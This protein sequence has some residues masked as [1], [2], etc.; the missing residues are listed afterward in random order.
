MSTISITS[1]AFE[2]GQP[3][4]EVYSQDGKNVSPPLEWSGVP[5]QVEELVLIVDDPDAPMDKPYVH[6]VMVGIPPSTDSLQEGVPQDP[7]PPAPRGALQGKNTAGN[8]G[9]DGPAPPP[10]HGVHHYHFK[11]YALDKSLDLDPGF[12]KEDIAEAI[13][14]HIAAQGELVGTYER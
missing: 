9:Y 13:K 7:T 12:T 1:P 4:P 10:G 6:W 3:I 5:D 2:H 11:L 8:P 14:G